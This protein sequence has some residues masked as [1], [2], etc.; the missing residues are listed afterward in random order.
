MFRNIKDF[1]PEY[2]GSSVDFRSQFKQF[3]PAITD[4]LLVNVK[5][6]LR[7]HLLPI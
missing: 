3:H 4:V 1:F 6:L 5:M 7:G 2:Y